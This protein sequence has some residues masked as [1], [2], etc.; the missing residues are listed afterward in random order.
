MRD[1]FAPWNDRNLTISV[2]L[3]DMVGLALRVLGT[4][5][6]SIMGQLFKSRL[7]LNASLTY[8]ISKYS[9]QQLVY[10]FRNISSPILFR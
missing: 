4:T 10:K 7:A 2:C 9:S 3:D 6:G 1:G 5:D 8:I